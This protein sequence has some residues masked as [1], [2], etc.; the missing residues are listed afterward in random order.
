MD[1]IWKIRPFSELSTLELYAIFH[2]RIAV[3]VVEQNCSYQDADGKDQASWHVMGFDNAGVLRAYSR[4]LP[5][6]LSF[7]EVSIGRVI[8]SDKARVTGAGRELMM[9]SLSFIKTSFGEVP[10][11]IGAQCYLKKFYSSFLFKVISDEYLED[12]IPHVEMLRH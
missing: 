2:L 9:Q 1:L 5:A 4:V 6:G 10:I 3:F 12:N 8:T 7:P 11:R